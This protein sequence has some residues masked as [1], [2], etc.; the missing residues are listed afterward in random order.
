MK[1]TNLLLG[2][3][4]VVTV[5]FTACQKNEDQSN[6]DFRKDVSN[7]VLAQIKALGFSTQDVIKTDEGYL[8]E[9]DILLTAENLNSKADRKILETAAEEQYHTT[10]LI[11]GLPRVITVSVSSSLPSNFGPAL[12]EALAR[13]NA[14]GLQLTFQR[15]SS[16]ADISIKAG[17][18]WWW[19]FGILGEGGFPTASGD[20]HNTIKMNSSAFSGA[21][22]GY[23]ATVLAHEIGHCIGF[24]HTDF[25]D[26]SFSCGGSATNEGDGGVGAIYI[27]GTSSGPESG[28]WMLS[29]SDG[30]DRPF[31]TNDKV[32][33][34][35][36]Y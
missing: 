30:S 33:L 22:V 4:L 14:E 3:A 34:D 26:R 16:G 2:V 18:W 28:S 32:A 31:T 5:L 35:Y 12:D 11:T 29:C 20:P 27:P 15:V 10:N 23:L 7:E 6:Q 17:P 25:M 8:V 36:L 21:S 13:Y 9:G 24:R 19:F 1:K